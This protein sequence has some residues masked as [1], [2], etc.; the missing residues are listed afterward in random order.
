MH[1]AATPGQD[2]ESFRLRVTLIPTGTCHSGDWF[3]L[4]HVDIDPVSNLSAAKAAYSVNGRHLLLDFNAG[5]CDLGDICGELDG[6]VFRGETRGGPFS[7]LGSD[8]VA[9][10]VIGWRVE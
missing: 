4:Q 5:W 1:I 8:Y 7:G 6:H 10:Q 3:E 2:A 9:R